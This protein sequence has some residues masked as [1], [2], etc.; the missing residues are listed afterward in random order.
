M[1]FQPAVY[2]LCLLAGV[3]ISLV[4]W[5]RLAQ[6]NDGLMLIYVAAL[7]GAFLGAKIVY[8]AAEGWLHFSDPNR[9]QQWATGKSILGGLMGGY[10]AVELAK[11]GL[12]YQQATGDWFASVVPLALALGR[13]GCVFQGCC[14]GRECSPQWY[15]MS[16][17]AGIARWPAALIEG[18]LNLVAFL[19]LSVLRHQGCQ[20]GQLFH[21]YLIAYGLFRFGH[22]FMRETPRVLGPLSGYQV[23]ALAIAALGTLGYVHRYRQSLISNGGSTQAVL[24]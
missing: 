5:R 21:L 22:E 7:V 11:K 9:W 3:G 15:T 24:S 12:R 17:S 6:R 16:D 23:A 1:T 18:I 4:F 20:R 2:G 13:V 19:V 14:L 10:A 8:L